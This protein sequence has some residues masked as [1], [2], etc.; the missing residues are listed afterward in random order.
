MLMLVCGYLVAEGQTYLRVIKGNKATQIY[1]RTELRYRTSEHRMQRASLLAMRDSLLFFDNG[2]TVILKN[3]R[4]ISIPNYRDGFQPFQKAAYIAA[5][6]LIPLS[7]LNQTI[8]G[9]GYRIHT[10]LITTSAT[11]F[12]AGSTFWYLRTKRIRISK[13]TVLTILE[14]DFNHLGPGAEKQKKEN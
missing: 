12:I 9:N 11:A 14:Q 3:L 4:K 2:D 13:N 7:M 8:L 1:P 6:G 10:A 5:F